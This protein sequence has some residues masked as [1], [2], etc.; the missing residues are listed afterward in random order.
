[1][2]IKMKDRVL[3]LNTTGIYL[4]TLYILYI[5]NVYIY[6]Y[7]C[8]R[9]YVYTYIYIQI[10]YIYRYIYI[11]IREYDLELTIQCNRKVMNFLD[12]TLNLENSSYCP[13]RQHRIQS[14]SV[15]NQT[16]VKINRIKIITVIGKR[17]NIEELNQTIQGGSNKSRV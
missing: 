15:H 3:R 5:H 12:V 14:S 13:Y 17:R 4:H 16:A 9:I 6:V 7:I 8:I 11:H 10:H 1:M 2:K